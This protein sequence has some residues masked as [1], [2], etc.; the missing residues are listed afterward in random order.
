ML[1][2]HFVVQK[3]TNDSQV[4][5]YQ[6]HT[7]NLVWHFESNTSPNNANGWVGR[8]LVSVREANT[9]VG[10]ANGWVGNVKISQKDANT[11]LA[12]HFVRLDKASAFV[13]FA[14]HFST[15][16]RHVRT[17]PT[18]RSHSPTE[19]PPGSRPRR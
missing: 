13:T 2:N 6:A 17:H 3:I 12:F 7:E 15:G 8:A 4:M 16:K 19:T 10:N 11:P 14:D 9:F 18:N 5:L 1:S